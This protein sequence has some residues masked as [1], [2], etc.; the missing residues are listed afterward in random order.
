MSLYVI[1]KKLSSTVQEK[2]TSAFLALAI[3]AMLVFLMW[4]IK[5][6]V[7]NPPFETKQ[8]VV[9]VQLDIPQMNVAS[10]AGGSG[11]EEVAHGEHGGGGN[12]EPAGGIG[13]VITSTEPDNTNYPPIKPPTTDGTNSTLKDKLK[14]VGNR[15]GKPGD[16]N[17]TS[18]T[19]GDWRSKTPGGGAG[20]SGGWKGP[21]SGGGT[22]LYSYNFTNY[23]M[24]STL[25]TVNADGTGTIVCRV[26]VDCGG[27]WSVVEYS[28]RGTTY[29]GSPSGLQKVVTSFLHSATFQRIGDKCP[30]SGYI[31]IEVK[32]KI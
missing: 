20:G 8:G 15:K 21:G 30:E 29:N 25:R 14:G 31:S 26:S 1:E 3:T 24:N 18:E 7:P 13:K 19:G 9:E 23:T 22:G 32:N 12:P 28:S 6:I 17:S 4:F 10:E 5:I 11:D 2:M 27:N 16:P